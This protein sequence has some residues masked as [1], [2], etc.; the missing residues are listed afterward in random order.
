MRRRPPAHLCKEIRPIAKA[1]KRQGWEIHGTRN[2]HNVWISPDGRK[3]YT[4]A[5]PSDPRA[6]KNFLAELRRNGYQE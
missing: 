1:A 5:T 4:S 3:V 6:M 2:S